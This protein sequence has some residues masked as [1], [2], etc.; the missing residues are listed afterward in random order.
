MLMTMLELDLRLTAGQVLDEC[1]RR[2]ITARSERE[3]AGRPGS[4]HWHLGF[5]DRSGTLELNEWEG[6]VWVKVHPLRDGGWAS[7]TAHDL[8]LL[9]RT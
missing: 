1:Q 6:R 2:G 8:A 3:L 9:N 7:T 4:R 5:P